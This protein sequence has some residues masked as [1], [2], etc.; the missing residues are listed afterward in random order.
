MNPLLLLLGLLGFGASS[1]AASR[2]SLGNAAASADTNT[3]DN[4]TAPEDQ[5]GTNVPN[6]VSADDQTPSADGGTTGTT[7]DPGTGTTGGTTT[8]SGTATDPTSGTTDNS[9][10]T[11]GSTDTGGSTGSTTTTGGSTGSTTG[12]SSGTT[13]GSG[14]STTTTTTT[15]TGSGTGTT[16]TTTTTTPTAPQQS[17]NT[18]G[19]GGDVPD[20]AAQGT[21]DVMAGRVATLSPPGS[22]VVSVDI[23]SGVQHGTLTVNPDNSFA[24]VMTQSNFVGSQSFTYEATHTDGSVTTHTVG[25]NVTPGLQA[26]GWGTGESHY[27]LATDAS[28]R[29][30][31]EHGDNHHAVYITGG[32]HGLSLQDIAT[33]EGM[34]VSQITGSWLANSSYGQS[35]ALA[36]DETAGMMLWNTV[37]PRGSSTSNWLM[38]ERDYQYSNLGRI[39]DRD[40]NGEDPNHPL[41]LGAWGTGERPEVTYQFFQHQ[42]SSSN[43]VVQ[44][45]AFG[46][47]V[48][49]TNGNNVIFDNIS[50]TGDEMVVMGSD[51]VTVRNSE[52]VDIYGAY[53][54]SGT[55]DA[56]VDRVQGIYMNYNDGALLE[57]NFFD[58]TAWADNYNPDG[59]TPGGQA[60]SMFSHN[61]YLDATMTDVTLRDT[62]T[63]RAASFGAQVRSGGFIEDNLFLDN[64]AALTAVGGDYAGAGPVGQ[65]TLMSD[66]V[67]TSGAH[68]DADLIGALT[69]GI[70]DE[71]ELTSLVDNIVTHLADPNNPNELSYKIWTHDSIYTE[72]TYY[73]DTIV[74]NWEGSRTIYGNYITDQN[75]AGLD[76]N[77]LDQTTIQLFTA[78]LLNDPNATIA[79]LADFIKT[80]ADG[81][82]DGVADADVIISFFQQGFGIA[83]N[84]RGAEQT[85]RFIPDDLGEGVRWDNRLNW[86]TEDLPG[87]YAQDDVDLGGNHVVYGSN[88]TIDELDFGPGGKLNVYGGRLDAT[89]GLS[90]HGGTL[91]IENAGQAWVG[92]SDGSDIDIDVTSGRFVNT[93]TM[94]GTDLTVTGGQA[95]LA[96]GGAEFELSDNK[97]LSIHGGAAKVGFDGDDGGIALLDLQDDSTLAFSAQNGGL[98][99]IEEF[100]SGAMGNAPDVQSGVDLGDATLSIDLSGL[101]GGTGSFKLMDTDEIV[102]VFSNAL[103][104][105]LGARNADVVIDY[106]NDT[107]T[108]LLSAGNG[109]VNIQT[110]GNQSDVTTGEQA[111][112]DA[113]TAGQGVVTETASATLSAQAN[114]LDLDDAA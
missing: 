112:W 40:T 47:G 108:L 72:S 100:R 66:N 64:N 58:H 79:D 43:L 3:D 16:T 57:G 4:S 91:N 69:L 92:G 89:G 55:W 67:V 87:L 61:M 53:K 48:F 101:S 105:N 106:Q 30:I 37:T 77:A 44:D 90:G 82:L 17:G 35:E 70:R 8:S 23:V 103:V 50:V 9:G 36:L 68:K 26:G 45:I 81:A 63:M 84:I 51:G 111:L 20:L 71:G 46:N 33:A 1:F 109:A 7:Q 65:Y 110:V 21:V 94:F 6:P 38:L 56:H 74:H 12:T 28:D 95:V 114:P 31:V 34:S 104:S 99:T 113:L 96:T 24:L 75:T 93:G 52:F 2:G 39:L 10:T 13:S 76:T 98:G 60:P 15:G 22:D 11:Q 97:T 18:G 25:L 42:E 107:V 78:Q 29:V 14:G 62:I 5:N 41:F 86:D 102:G 27:M 73:D 88:T 80:R 32:A 85:V 19:D 83:P 49:F 54:T 59:S